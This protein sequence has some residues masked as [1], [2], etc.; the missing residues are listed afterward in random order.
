MREDEHAGS[1]FDSCT[2]NVK[3]LAFSRYRGVDYVNCEDR[4][5]ARFL[6]CK[7]DSGSPNESYISLE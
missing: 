3:N 2:F 4:V 5:L 6:S 7:F 1:V